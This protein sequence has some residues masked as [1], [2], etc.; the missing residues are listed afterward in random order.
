MKKVMAILENDQTGTI[1]L[2]DF[3]SLY[4][5]K[6]DSFFDH[7]DVNHDG[8]VE[9][10]EFEAFIKSENLTLDMLNRLSTISFGN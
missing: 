2:Q 3:K 9:R 6:P 10:E 5:E 4:P 1:K 8:H 7:F